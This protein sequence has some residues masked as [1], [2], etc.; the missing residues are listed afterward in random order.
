MYVVQKCSLH[1]ASHKF[2]C[3]VD[4]HCSV[5]EYDDDEYG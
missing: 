1:D 3:F 5:N 4:S 2:L